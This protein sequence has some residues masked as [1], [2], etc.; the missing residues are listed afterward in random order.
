VERRA[1]DALDG[2]AWNCRAPGLS[3]AP[4]L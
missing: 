2:I 1:F 4:L 3:P